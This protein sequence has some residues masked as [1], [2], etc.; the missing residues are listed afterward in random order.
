ME[1]IVVLQT[2]GEIDPSVLFNLREKI[3]HELKN[4]NFI[5]KVNSNILTLSDLEYNTLKNQY[6]AL[7]ILKKIRKNVPRKKN[8]RILGVMND[9]IYSKNYKFIFG[10]ASRIS[11]IGIISLTRLRESFYRDF[12]SLYRKQET[13]EDIERRILKEALHELGHTFGL[14]HC[15]NHCIMKFSNSLIDTDNKPK[16]FCN[17]CND[18][19]KSLLYQLT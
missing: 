8:F 19:L 3:D 4:F 12:G 18:K 15:F 13:I 16:E 17:L 14:E 9:D 7:K 1:R 11:G 5:I 6:N 10:L 2:I